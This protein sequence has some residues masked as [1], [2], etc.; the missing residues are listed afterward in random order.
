[1]T[2][3]PDATTTAADD[4]KPGAGERLGAAI[5]GAQDKL[6]EAVDHAGDRV[7]D[8]LAGGR[9][10]AARHAVEAMD[11]TEMQVDLALEKAKDAVQKRPSPS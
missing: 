7:K 5:D 9:D 3:D 10:D 8:A 4:E 2:N 6:T 1:M 11:A